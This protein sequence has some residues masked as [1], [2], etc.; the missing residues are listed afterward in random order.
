MRQFA[1]VPELGRE[2]EVVRQLPGGLVVYRGERKW[3]VTPSY[4]EAE[5]SSMT[6]RAAFSGRLK[7]GGVFMSRVVSPV[8]PCM[9]SPKR[10]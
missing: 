3:P 1:D 9:L 2:V 7:I 5:A 6:V 10:V 4:S 8:M